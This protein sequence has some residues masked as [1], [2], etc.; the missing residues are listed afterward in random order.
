MNWVYFAASYSFP[1][2][3]SPITRVLLT[4]AGALSALCLA[5]YPPHFSHLWDDGGAWYQQ[6]AYSVA[7]ME[8]ELAH[9]GSSFYF[10]WQED[11]PVG[12]L[13]LNTQTRL[14]GHS[15]VNGLEVERIYLLSSAQ[16]LGL[17]KQLLEFAEAQAELGQKDHLFLYSMDSST[18]SIAFYQAMGFVLFGQKR[19]DF[20][21]M[22]PKF[23]GMCSLVKTLARSPINA[24]LG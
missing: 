8:I 6:T 13:K 15:S 17:G 10:I 1:H 21:L 24:G 7:Q 5:I 14:P 12:Y 2:M 4:E 22:K 20:P 3:Q 19:L 18:A 16:G 11:R 9:P 23:R